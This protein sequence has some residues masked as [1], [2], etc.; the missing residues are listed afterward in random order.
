[1]TLIY[2]LLAVA[3]IAVWTQYAKKIRAHK[4]DTSVTQEF[5]R[6]IR[7]Q[8]PLHFVTELEKNLAYTTA[9]ANGNMKHLIYVC[10]MVKRNNDPNDP[11]LPLWREEQHRR[12][13]QRHLELKAKTYIVTN[14]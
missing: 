9:R 2:I 7:E 11:G 1:M 12:A 13:A 14:N 8:V 10:A 6:Q 4:F 5:E 3:I